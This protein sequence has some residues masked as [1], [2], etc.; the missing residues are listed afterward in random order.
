MSLGL[1]ARSQFLGTVDAVA[2]APYVAVFFPLGL[3]SH[4]G[5]V[6]HEW[7]YLIVPKI[8]ETLKPYH[9][10][11]VGRGMLVVGISRK[12]FLVCCT[13]GCSGSGFVC[14]LKFL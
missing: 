10:D 14:E 8:I 13:G 6:R 12:H 7:L 3:E 9:D 4:Y 1:T 5:P 11:T 2:A